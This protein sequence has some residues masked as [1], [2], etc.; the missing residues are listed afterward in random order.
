MIA[1]SFTLRLAYLLTA[2]IVFTVN[3]TGCEATPA[4]SPPLLPQ[5]F[6]DT[7]VPN[8]NLEGYVYFN[9]GSPITISA[10]ILQGA[11]PQISADSA[12]VW[13]GPDANSIGGAV[14]FKSEADAQS[15]SRL[16]KAA[17]EPVWN[18]A[19]GQIIYAAYNDPGQ[20]TASLKDAVNRQQMVSP[21][22]KYPEIS[23][24]FAYFPNKPSVKP[25]AAGFIDLNGRLVESIGTR[26][27]SSLT[28]YTS[29]LGSAKINHI[30]FVLYGERPIE[31]SSRAMSEEYIK[32]LNL[33]VM[34]VGRSGYPGIAISLFFDKAMQ[35]AGLTK[36]SV[37]GVDVYEYPA[38]NVRLLVARKGNVIYVAAAL[39][40]EIAEN[41]L[42]SS[43][44]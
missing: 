1:K 34:V 16:I 44:K 32:S 13:L 25:F 23:G 3:L 14:N 7:L 38:G 5:G 27:G 31:I 21:K 28:D 43:F 12:Q 22:I 41:L 10:D 8:V 39:S 18:L 6:A 33:G 20:W 35:D 40:K 19:S 4:A 29:A 15:V 42:L 36:Y 2:L 17:G 9:Q 24:D 30:S 11:A 37:R 26:L